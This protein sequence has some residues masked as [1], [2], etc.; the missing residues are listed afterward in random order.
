MINGDTDPDSPAFFQVRVGCFLYHEPF[1][2]AT[3]V[4]ANTIMDSQDFIFGSYNY[5][6]KGQFSVL[7]DKYLSVGNDPSSPHFL[8]TVSVSLDLT[9][10]PRVLFAGGAGA[11]NHIFGFVFSNAGDIPGVFS[12]PF[13]AMSSVFYYTDS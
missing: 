10:L 11:K 7:Y 2:L 12:A 1:P 4:D 13:A 5:D 8:H 9:S 3:D 6:R